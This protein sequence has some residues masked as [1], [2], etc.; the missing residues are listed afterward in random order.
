MVPNLLH[1][2]CL[3]IQSHIIYTVHTEWPSFLGL[4]VDFLSIIQHKIHV[5]IKA[6]L[7]KKKFII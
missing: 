3:W 2:A 7:G 1:L 4:K 5:L 6:L